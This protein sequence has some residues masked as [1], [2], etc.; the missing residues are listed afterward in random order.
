MKKLKKIYVN[1]KYIKAIFVLLVFTM[2]FTLAIVQPINEGPDE[3]MKMDICQYI[4]KHN[5]LPHGGDAEVRQPMWGISYGFTPILSYIIGGIFVKI[6]TA[7]TQDIHIQYIAARLVSVLCYTGMCIFNIKIAEKLFKNFAYKWFFIILTSMLPQLLFIG[8]Y[9]NNDSLALFSISIIIYSWLKGLE[10]SWN[11]K[12]CITLSVGLALCALSYYNAYGYILTSVI[13]F[14]AS[15][16]INKNDE[17]KIAIK[18]LF[19]KG[20]LIAGIT[21]ILCGWWFI[22][23]AIIYNGDFLG[24]R[25][26]NEYAEKYAIDSLKPSHRDTP[27]NMNVGLKVMLIDRKWLTTTIK[28]FIA[29]FGPM[30]IFMGI[31]FYTLYVLAFL[32]GIIGYVSKFYKFNHIKNWKKDKN[33]G[34]LEVIFAVN[35][36]IPICLS[37]YY[38][39][40][41]DFQPQGRYIM[42]MIMPFMYFVVSGLEKIIEKVIKNEKVKRCMQYAIMVIGIILPVLCLIKLIRMY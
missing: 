25:T 28:S 9:I 8:S 24:L 6:A 16:F 33:K 39:Y 34:L 1:E 20:F 26:T 18:N 11:V 12:S 10:S 31:K 40:C 19:K 23:S 36:I 38:S 3:Q 17:N 15:Y 27:Q 4:A 7:F 5:A 37:I 2:A 41:S 32:L 42:P 22:R 21:F 13:L 35:V 14:I 30:R 29:V